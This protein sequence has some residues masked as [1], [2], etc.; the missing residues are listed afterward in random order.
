MLETV[1]AIGDA[2]PGGGNAELAVVGGK[3]NVCQHCDLHAAAEA[4]AADAGNRRLRVTRQQRALR[5]APFRIFFRG[6]RIVAGLFELADIGARD[7]SLVAGADQDHHAN[8]GIVAQLD[9][10]MAQALPHFERHGVALVGIVEGDD[11]DAI[12]DALQDLAVGMGCF[13]AFGDVEHRLRLSVGELGPLS[14]ERRAEVN[15]PHLA[16]RQD[17]NR[18]REGL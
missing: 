14:D 3:A 17:R 2:E 15:R 12:A 7:K 8:V 18:C 1:I 16:W 11:A 4:E 9:Q 6:R 5:L 10:R 13:G